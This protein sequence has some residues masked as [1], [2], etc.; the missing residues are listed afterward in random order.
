[1]ENQTTQRYFSFVDLMGL[2]QRYRAAFVNS[3]SGFKSLALIGTA[4]SSKQTNLAIFNSLFHIG[5]NPPYIGFISRPDSVDRHTLS[6]IMETGFY[7]INHI[8][9]EIYKQAHQTSARYAREISE[10]DA[11]HLTP[12]YKLGF[13]A[14]F[15]KESHIQM[16]VQF[17]E[18]INITTNNT[19]L[20]IGQINQVY[21]PNDC[22]CTDGF[23]DIEKAKTITCSGLDSYHKTERL[24]RLS[25]AKADR[26]VSLAKLGYIE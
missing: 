19:V 17:K 7:T 10:F 3:L 5:A 26:D 18:R 6:N 1:M 11:T 21:F 9:E 16:G 24:A 25:Y 20:V 2:E 8:N 22:L 15:V 12:D 13:K 14:P 4:N 23:L